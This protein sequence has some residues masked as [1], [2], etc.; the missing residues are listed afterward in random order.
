MPIPTPVTPEGAAGLA[1]ILADPEHALLALDFDGVLA[2]IV[3]DPT[4]ARP[5]PRM[6]PALARIA[7]QVGW[8]A[9]VTGR[10]A[11]VAVGY[12][13]LAGARGLGEL[14][15]F[16]QYGRERWEARTGEVTAPPPH[17]GVAAARA[18]LPRLLAELDAG[19]AWVE[20]KGGAIAVHTRRSDDPQGTLERLR[21]PIAGLAELLELVV[22]PG[23][24]VLELRPPGT[25]KGH[26]LRAYAAET[27][28]RSVA[29][30]GDDLGDLPAFAAVESLR[31]NGVPGLK[32]ASGSVEVTAVA[33]RADLV[34][35]GP[36][37]VADLLDALADALS[38]RVGQ[39]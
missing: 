3:D 39:A 12:G 22:E 37:G 5:H 18:E 8:V 4:Q 2:P 31:A 7:P 14:V 11:E 32:V 19:T 10:P 23:R 35:D 29:Y 9:I 36:A 21:G 20:D 28:A 13:G 34:V 27:G 33:Q 15:V 17:P 24:L 38:Q 16:G 26:T 6:L 1:A 25:D 30:A